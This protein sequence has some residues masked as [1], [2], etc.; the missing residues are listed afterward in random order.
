MLR[1]C[2]FLSVTWLMALNVDLFAKGFAIA[3]S[4]VT[5]GAGVSTILKNRKK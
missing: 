2:F 5:I 1:N 3:A 4:V